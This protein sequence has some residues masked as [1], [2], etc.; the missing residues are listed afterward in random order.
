V[1]SP[2]PAILVA[3][4]FFKDDLKEAA[5]CLKPLAETRPPCPFMEKIARDTNFELNAIKRRSAIPA[6][7]RYACDDV[8][9]NNQINAR[10]N[11]GCFAY[12]SPRQVIY[13]LVCNESS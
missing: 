3:A 1:G 12:T 10:D 2:A 9:I 7:R 13:P 4:A 8:F 5:D 11:A 6:N